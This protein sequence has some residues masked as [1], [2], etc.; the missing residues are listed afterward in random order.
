MG[1]VEKGDGSSE[2]SLLSRQLGDYFLLFMKR[3]MIS[4]DDTGTRGVGKG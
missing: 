4:M 1:V 3:G 2:V